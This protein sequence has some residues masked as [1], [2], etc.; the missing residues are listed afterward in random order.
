[1]SQSA[2]SKVRSAASGLPVPDDSEEMDELMDTGG[3]YQDSRPQ[4][5]NRDNKRCQFWSFVSFFAIWILGVLF[6]GISAIMELTFISPGTYLPKATWTWILTA[7]A[8][9]M[10]CW[11]VHIAVSAYMN[12]RAVD[13]GASELPCMEPYYTVT[14]AFFVQ[15][16][17]W[18]IALGFEADVYAHNQSSNPQPQQESWI[19][20]MWIVE[21][22]VL[23][24]L[25][26]PIRKLFGMFRD[27]ALARTGST[28]YD[29]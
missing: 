21:I 11:F 29:C 10:F 24:S 26:D 9:V 3:K 1:M 12:K 8:G 4:K 6:I 13:A 14:Y 16:A 23:V 20:K 19:T 7:A 5:F 2:I 17:A 18:A 15:L 25:G 28:C 27:K 22:A